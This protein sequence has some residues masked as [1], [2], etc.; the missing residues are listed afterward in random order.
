MGGTSESLAGLCPGQVKGTEAGLGRAPN[1]ERPLMTLH[2]FP[3]PRLFPADLCVSCACVIQVTCTCSAG[4]PEGQRGTMFWGHRQCP[5]KEDLS[6]LELTSADG[7]VTSK[8][9]LVPSCS[10]AH[11]T[12]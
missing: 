9:T 6:M 12:T 3:T 11:C 7:L 10:V 1:P 2:S 8:V 5:L 4:E